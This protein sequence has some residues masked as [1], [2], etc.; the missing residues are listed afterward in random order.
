MFMALNYF[1]GLFSARGTVWLLLMEKLAKM[2]VIV[3]LRGA[4]STKYCEA[5]NL[6]ISTKSNFDALQCSEKESFYFKYCYLVQ[7]N[8]LHLQRYLWVVSV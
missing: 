3:K 7:R 2:T 5:E 6:T 1:R 8:Y 4:A